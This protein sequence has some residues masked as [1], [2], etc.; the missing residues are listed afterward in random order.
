M[1]PKNEIECPQTIGALHCPFGQDP[2]DGANVSCQQIG[3]MADRVWGKLRSAW[4]SRWLQC[5]LHN[6]NFFHW[7]DLCHAIKKLI[8]S[9]KEG[10]TIF[11][12]RKRGGEKSEQLFLIFR[13]RRGP[14]NNDAR[15]GTEKSGEIPFN[16][17]KGLLLFLFPSEIDR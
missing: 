5:T 12:R 2:G 8:P 11:R 10:L 15:H 6:R 17:P 1:F 3:C 16:G 4:S 9:S 7:L 14:L 13:F